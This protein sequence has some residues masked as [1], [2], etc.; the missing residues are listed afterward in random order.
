MYVFTT[1]PTLHSKRVR[2]RGRVTVRARVS[3][4][5]S[6]GHVQYVGGD[7]GHDNDDTKRKRRGGTLTTPTK[8][9]LP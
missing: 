4:I 2:V 6:H 3:K 8:S 5:R 9:T 7:D 1:N